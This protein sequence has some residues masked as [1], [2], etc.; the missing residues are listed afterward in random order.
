[1]SFSSELLQ[2]F[3]RQNEPGGCECPPEMIP[4]CLQSVEDICRLFSQRCKTFKAQNERTRQD[5]GK[6]K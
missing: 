6:L 4:F 3:K 1:M 2:G 5:S